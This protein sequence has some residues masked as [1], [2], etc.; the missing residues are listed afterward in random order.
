MGTSARFLK[1]PWCALAQ[2]EGVAG[3][4]DH[5]SVPGSNDL[6]AVIHDEEVF[7]SG[8]VTCIGHPIG[9]IV[10]DT[11]ARAR[12]AAR[13][14]TVTY[15]N[16]PAILSIDQAVAARSFFDVRLPSGPGPLHLILV[17]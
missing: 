4:F 15:E 16:L 11:E 1:G 2:M 6:G 14:V 5:T 8:V 17:S 7:A 9:V 10:A 12:A 3:Y 13:A